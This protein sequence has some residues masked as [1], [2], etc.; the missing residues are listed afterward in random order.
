M[1]SSGRL[2]RKSSMCVH[3]D[4]TPYLRTV[5]GNKGGARLTEGLAARDFL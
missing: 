4:A 3:T 1:G 5:Y 2:K